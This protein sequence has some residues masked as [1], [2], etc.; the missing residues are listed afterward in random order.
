MSDMTIEEMFAEHQADV[1]SEP[2]AHEDFW[3]EMEQECAL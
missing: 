1:D 2:F 3:A